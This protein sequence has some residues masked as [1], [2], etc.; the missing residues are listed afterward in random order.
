MVV[1]RRTPLALL[2]FAFAGCAAPSAVECQPTV[3]HMTPPTE[4]LE[5]MIRGSSRPEGARR[6]TPT[7]NWYGNDAMWVVLP[8]N[9]ELVERL[10]DKIAPYRMKRGQ[11]TWSARQLDGKSSVPTQ[12][13]IPGYGDLGFQAGG[14]RFPNIGCWEV[15][16]WLA[17]RD[18]LKF[19]LRVR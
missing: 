1:I 16:Y 18:E 6:I 5:F 15:S 9:G 17:G 3:A 19:V 10:S 12:T 13:M 14:P 2:A 8:A 4:P 11:V 7:L